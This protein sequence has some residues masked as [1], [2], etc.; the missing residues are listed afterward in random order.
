MVTEQTIFV[1]YTSLQLLMG[2]IDSYLA[3]PIIHSIEEAAS[4]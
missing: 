1:L 3:N 4:I 2:I